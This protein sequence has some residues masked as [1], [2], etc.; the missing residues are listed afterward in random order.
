MTVLDTIKVAETIFV[1]NNNYQSHI[2]GFVKH[3]W[4]YFLD[5]VNKF[6]KISAKNSIIGVWQDP[7]YPTNHRR[8]SVK[9][10]FLEIL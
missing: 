10:V 5:S 2:Q 1:P 9:Q 4:W 7:N 6:S 8:C 3:L